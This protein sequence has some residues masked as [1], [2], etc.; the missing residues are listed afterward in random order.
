M[1]I[2]MLCKIR[3]EDETTQ[4]FVLNE[5][6][7]ILPWTEGERNEIC[8]VHDEYKNGKWCEDHV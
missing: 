3:V 7:H 1:M 4:V 2:L 5:V 6:Q 8:R